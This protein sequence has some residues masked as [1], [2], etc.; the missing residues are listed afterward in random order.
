MLE[1]RVS[2]QEGLGKDTSGEKKCMYGS[3]RMRV[4]YHT[5]RGIISHSFAETGLGDCKQSSISVWGS[6]KI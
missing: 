4:R 5:C 1:D 6:S 2:I 3:L